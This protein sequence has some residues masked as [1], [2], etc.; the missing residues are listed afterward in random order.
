[1]IAVKFKHSR[2]DQPNRNYLNDEAW[3]E[4]ATAPCDHL[5][6][7]HPAMLTAIAEHHHSL[8]SPCIQHVRPGGFDRP[9]TT[10]V[11]VAVVAAETLADATMMYLPGQTRSSGT[12]D[13]RRL[14]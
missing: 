1:V 4:A 10:M 12:G 6:H 8:C 5:A 14:S 3:E 9:C 11:A 7:L 13:N 2:P